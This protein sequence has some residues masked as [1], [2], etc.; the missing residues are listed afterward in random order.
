LILRPI[1]LGNHGD[2]IALSG[3]GR[4]VAPIG[5]TWS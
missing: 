4:S 5:V 2:G 3:D 1:L